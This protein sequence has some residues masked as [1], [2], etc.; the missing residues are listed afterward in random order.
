MTK[1]YFSTAS[2]GVGDHFKNG[3]S[4]KSLMSR[5]S[6]CSIIF[7]ALIFSL[8][9]CGMVAI[10]GVP[11]SQLLSKASVS[12]PQPCKDNTDLERRFLEAIGEQNIVK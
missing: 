5:R 6:I 11:A 1:D 3:A 4:L 9:G 12:D 8:T 10:N 2:N 7:C